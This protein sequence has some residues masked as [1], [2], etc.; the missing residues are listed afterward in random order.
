MLVNDDLDGFADMVRAFGD[1]AARREADELT[2]ILTSPPNI[3]GAALFHSDG[4]YLVAKGQSALEYGY[5]EGTDGPV[6]T[7]RE[8]FEVDGMEFK[9]RLDFGCGWANPLGWIKSAGKAVET[10]LG[11]RASRVRRQKLL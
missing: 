10:C 1:A 9:A 5:L 6:R 2:T 4:R 3:D 8:G 11:V 7:T